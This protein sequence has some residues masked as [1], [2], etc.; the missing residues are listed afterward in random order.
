M[1]K[2]PCK[3]CQKREMGCHGFCE[4]YQKAK[5]DREA[6]LRAQKKETAFDSYYCDSR[7]KK[8][9]S[10]SFVRKPLGRP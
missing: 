7:V 6:E 2:F 9:R 3:V 10:N 8:E 4:E 5:T 1:A